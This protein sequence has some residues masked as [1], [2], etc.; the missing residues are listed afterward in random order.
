M[1]LKQEKKISQVCHNFAWCAVYV[2]Y[3]YVVAFLL[4]RNLSRFYN[5]RTVTWNLILYPANN[6]VKKFTLL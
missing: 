2:T 4:P 5:D 3:T 6:M 1:T